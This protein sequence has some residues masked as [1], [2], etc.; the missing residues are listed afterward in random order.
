VAAQNL[1]TITDYK[2]YD[3]EISHQ[4][5]SNFPTGRNTFIFRRGIDIGTLPQPRTFIAGVQFNF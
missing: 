2:G 4:E 1:F 3:P 5:L